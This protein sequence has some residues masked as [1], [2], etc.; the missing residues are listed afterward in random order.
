MPL[1]EHD[2]GDLS[3]FAVGRPARVTV[4]GRALVVVRTA[5]GVLAARDVCPHQAARLSEGVVCGTTLRCKPGDDIEYGREGEILTC[6]WHGWEYD[7]TT[8]KA[9]V[10]PERARVATYTA[11][12]DEDRVIVQM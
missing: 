10:D 1:T 8:G 4:S 11:R 9:L 12:V 2:V 7:L 3:D 5:R 6:P